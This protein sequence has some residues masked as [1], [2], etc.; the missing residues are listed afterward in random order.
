MIIIT[1]IFFSI[2]NNVLYLQKYYVTLSSQ[3]LPKQISKTHSLG[4]DLT[5]DSLND[6]REDQIGQLHELFLEI[7]KL[8]EAS[9]KN[10]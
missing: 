1:I 3:L 9:A 4:K 6:L 10:P 8:N 7:K 5:F 2:N